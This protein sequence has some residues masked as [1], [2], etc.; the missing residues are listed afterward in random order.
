MDKWFMCFIVTL[1]L[2]PVNSFAGPLKVPTLE[3]VWEVDLPVA[4]T[5]AYDAS[6]KVIYATGMGE[7][8]NTGVTWKLSL[9]GTILA[10]D[11]ATGLNQVRGSKFANGFLYV[12]ELQGIAKVDLSSGKVVKRY[13]APEAKMFNNI[14]VD[15]KGNLYVTDTPGNAIYKLDKANDTLEK[16]LDT[17]A[18]EWPNGILFEKG[19]LILAP[20]GT[21]TDPNTWGTDVPGRIQTLS[22]KTKELKFLGSNQKPLANGD[23]L[24]SDGKGNYFVGDWMSGKIYIVNKASESALVTTVAQGMGDFFYIEKEKLFLVPVGKLNKL[25]AYKVK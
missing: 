15:D 24:V 7:K 25:F 13:P 10:K 16:W 22:I 1:V 20:W 2:L 8:P 6:K 21:V 3:K 18:L 14:A 17:P 9:D 19:Q 12:A 11:W 5:A 23:G 4:E